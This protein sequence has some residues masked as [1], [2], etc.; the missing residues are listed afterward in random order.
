[1]KRAPLQE[2]FAE[3]L[4]RVLD[5]RFTLL[6]DVRLDGVDEPI[7]H[8]LVG[9]AGIWVIF[10]S[11]EKGVFYARESG[12]AGLDGKTGE[13][14]SIRPNPITSSLRKTAALR[15]ELDKQGIQCPQIEAVLHFSDPGA[16]VQTEKPAVRIVLIDGLER[17]IQNILTAP[18]L[19]DA[20]TIEQIVTALLGVTTQ[21]L[22]FPSGEIRDQYSMSEPPAPKKPAEPLRIAQISRAEPGFIQSL[23]S[24]LPFTRR[25]WTL[26]AILLVANVIILLLLVIV[27]VIIT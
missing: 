19:L 2:E 5:H 17:F 11:N 12:W 24:K 23:S 8:I 16:H 6:C 26:L 13:F 27:I 3:A 15:E 1:M 9:P 14:R 25:Q 21:E 18:G 7:P 4:N 20:N 22:L 10:H